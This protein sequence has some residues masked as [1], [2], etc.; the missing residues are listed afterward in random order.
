M[1]TLINITL[2][3]SHHCIL[4]AG[5]VFSTFADPQM[6][7][8]GFVLGWIIMKTSLILNLVDL[9]NEICAFDDET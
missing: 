4:G 7:M 8:D 1:K 2:G 6:K 5:K 3:L 9:D